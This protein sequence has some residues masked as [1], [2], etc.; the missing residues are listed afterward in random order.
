[1]DKAERDFFLLKLAENKNNY[2]EIFNICNGLLGRNKDLPLP[3]TDNIQSLANSFNTYFREKIEKIHIKLLEHQNQ[4]SGDGITHEEEPGSNLQLLD[5]FKEVDAEYITKL[6]SKCPTKSCE[7]DPIPTSLLK[8]IMPVAAP[9]IVD[10]VNMSLGSGVFPMEYKE[11]LVRPLL[12]KAGLPLIDKNYRPVSNLAFIGKLIERVVADQLNDHISKFNLM[13]PNQL[14]YRTGHSTETTLLRVKSDILA[15]MDSREVVCLVLL[16]L[17]AAFDTVDHTILLDRLATRFGFT[18][19]VLAWLKSYLSD[20]TQKV[21]I[22]DHNAEGALS[23]PM[24]LCR[25]VPQG[26]VLGPLLFT[27]YTTPLGNICRRHEVLFQLYADDQ[28]VYLSFRPNQ[29][30]A[31][32]RCIT[33][34]QNCIEEVRSWMRAN[35]L[36]LN[37]DKT[38]FVVFG[39]QYQLAKISSIEIRIGSECV[40]P[41]EHVRNLGFFMD[42]FMKNAVHINKIC[43]QMFV[44]LKNISLIRSRLDNTTTKILVQALCLSKM[45][46]C[47]SLLAGS[48]E[49]QLDKLQRTQNMACRVICNLGKFDQVSTSMAGLHWLRICQR[50]AY[51]LACLVY[52]C[53]EGCAPQYLMDLIPPPAR[54]RN[55]RSSTNTDYLLPC[56]SKTALATKGSFA[57][58]GP[59]TWNALPASVK[60]HRTWDSFA[61][62]LKTYL[63]NLSYH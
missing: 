16:D 1:M 44:L 15:A 14:A 29:E 26:S 24:V 62:A 10:I 43:S 3:P 38:E 47:N 49:Y 21:A 7:L 2:K 30:A 63:F 31:Q 56:R 35:M 12:K 59:R 19:K 57:S 33:T 4:D 55:L 18:G 27:L 54:A 61:T 8:S 17:S 42:R 13:E 51:K 22:G 9:L 28:Q 39:T 53:R 23:D 48:T 5:G 6:V 58:A 20:R 37:E 25:G 60:Q 11:A 41:V 50:I 34:I 36:K 32:D 52:K 46:Y 45:D 40:M